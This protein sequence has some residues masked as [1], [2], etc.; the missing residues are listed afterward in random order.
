MKLKKKKKVIQQSQN[1][2]RLKNKDNK[3]KILKAIEE[4]LLYAVTGII[5]FSVV[6]FIYKKLTSTLKSNLKSKSKFAPHW[7]A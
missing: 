7:A 1:K 4:Y 6:L 2:H 5:S 3:S